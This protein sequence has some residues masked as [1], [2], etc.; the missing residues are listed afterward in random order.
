MA[1]MLVTWTVGIDRAGNVYD[2]TQTHGNS[3]ADVYRG[4]HQI[5]AEV[6]R[7]IAERRNCPFNPKNSDEL[8]AVMASWSSS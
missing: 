6:E 7:Q 3:F 8:D 2:D 1:E 4:F 5:R